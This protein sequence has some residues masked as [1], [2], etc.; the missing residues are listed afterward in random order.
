[1]T[2]SNFSIH[3][4]VKLAISSHPFKREDG[5]IWG[6]DHKFVAIN[7]DGEET[8]ISIYGKDGKELITSVN[9]RCIEEVA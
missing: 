2:S 1:M 5:K 3:R 9:G 6:R 4:V 8:E 7:D